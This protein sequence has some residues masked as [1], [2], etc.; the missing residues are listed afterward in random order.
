MIELVFIVCLSADPATCERRALQF[1][2]VSTTTCVIAAQ[3]ELARWAG[4]HPDWRIQR[5]TCQPI[6]LGRDA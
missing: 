6:R 3:P 4:E 5:W 2:D 1:T